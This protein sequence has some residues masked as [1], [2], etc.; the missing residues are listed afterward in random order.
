MASASRRS[1]LV[2][3]VVIGCL[4][5]TSLPAQTAPSTVHCRS[6]GEYVELE[7]RDTI[8]RS[9]VAL[10]DSTFESTTQAVSQG[11]LVRYT[12]RLSAAGQPRVLHIEIWPHIA[13][14]ASAPAQIADVTVDGADVQARV[15]APTRGIQLQHDR[16]PPGGILCM[17]GAPLFLEFLQRQ[18]H[19]P[20]GTTGT[21]PVLWLFTGGH[22]DTV[23]VTRPAA[24]SVV[25]RFPDAEY[26]LALAPD[27]SILAGTS[28]SRAAA[29]DSAARLVRR[30][31]R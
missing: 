4:A 10:T 20:V 11:A 14:S 30:D 1:H 29:T 15:A 24:D 18:A 23:Q 6:T 2:T 17:T 31:C 27:H 12:G 22:V 3:L 5:G 7:G 8:M 28:R 16:L 9:R 13:D 19:L 26:A 25:L 21:V